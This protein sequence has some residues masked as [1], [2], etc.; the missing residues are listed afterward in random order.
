MKSARQRAEASAAETQELEGRLLE[1]SDAEQRRIGHDLHDGLGQHLTGIALMTRRLERR[2][3]AAGSADAD[4]AAKLCELAKTA[5]GWTHDLSRSLS[6]PALD[7]AGLPEALRELAAHVENLFSIQCVAECSPEFERLNLSAGA[8]LYRIAQEAIT[9]AVRHGHARQVQI[10]LERID[11]DTLSLSVIDDGRGIDGA[12]EPATE[13]DGMGLRIM[14]YRA[15]MIGASI[16]VAHPVSGGTVVSCRYLL[17][18]E[19]QEHE[20]VEPA[21]RRRAEAQGEGA[22]G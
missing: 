19:P 22:L 20:H 4:E 13:S 9:N 18:A 1:I 21:P 11:G 15:R 7:S 8:H 17:P 16:A 6:P 3:A 2:L 10:R 5:V 12:A 14:R